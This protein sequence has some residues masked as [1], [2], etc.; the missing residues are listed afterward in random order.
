MVILCIV[1]TEKPRLRRRVAARDGRAARRRPLV[2]SVA[3]RNGRRPAS[4]V[5]VKLT[6]AAAGDGGGGHVSLSL[7]HGARVGAAGSTL[8][9]ERPNF[10]LYSP[11][12]RRYDPTGIQRPRPQRRQLFVETGPTSNQE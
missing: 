8:H 11:Y 3:R 6:A 2:S 10:S 7:Y 9:R 5:R 4:V 12:G 1:R